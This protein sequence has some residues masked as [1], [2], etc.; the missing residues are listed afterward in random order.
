[1]DEFLSYGPQSEPGKVNLQLK[2]TML[3]AVSIN[4][5][6]ETRIDIYI[7]FF[8]LLV[9]WVQVGKPL[10]RKLKDGRVLNWN[11]ETDSP[12]CTLE[13][14]F[15]KVD[16]HLGFN[17]ELKFDDDMIYQ[18]EEL[19]RILQVILQVWHLSHLIA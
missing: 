2:F 5:G 17:V 9:A 7:Y 6:N 18:E 12:F 14:A 15:E 4:F 1:M 19:T 3:Q 11:V 13:E 8:F 16:S 10:L